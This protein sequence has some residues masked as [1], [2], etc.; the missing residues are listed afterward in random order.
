M[1]QFTNKQ[2]KDLKVLITF[3]SFYC[4]ARHGKNAEQSPLALPAEL[5]STFKRN[6]HLCGECAGLVAYAIEKRRRCP[7]DPKPSCKKCPIHCYSK[8]YRAKIREVMA[9][10][11]KRMIMRG[12]LDLLWHYLF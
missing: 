6:M 5:N 9:F 11:G 12:R 8:E 7:L 10:S 4:R 3:V 1:E 2:K